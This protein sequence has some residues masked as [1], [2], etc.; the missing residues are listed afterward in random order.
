MHVDNHSLYLPDARRCER[1]GEKRVVDVVDVEEVVVQFDVV[2][3]AAAPLWMSTRMERRMRRRNMLALTH[4]RLQQHPTALAS[5]SAATRTREPTA[6][7][8]GGGVD[9]YLLARL[10]TLWPVISLYNISTRMG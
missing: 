2:R 5:L 1:L 6:E 8:G 9:A 7:S 4:A 10:I 3:N